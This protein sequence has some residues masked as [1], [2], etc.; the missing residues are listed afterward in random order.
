[1]QNFTSKQQMKA[2]EALAKKK[3]IDKKK[4][5]AM[6][7]RMLALLKIQDTLLPYRILY[8][9]EKA[10]SQKALKN[11]IAPGKYYPLEKLPN[12][13]ECL[14][15]IPACKLDEQA[16]MK[17]RKE[18]QIFEQEEAKY[19]INKDNWQYYFAHFLLPYDIDKFTEFDITGRIEKKVTDQELTKIKQYLS[20][21][22]QD[23][24]EHP[25]KYY[26]GNVTV[27]CN[28]FSEREDN[29]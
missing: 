3:E 1:M 10:E 28:G 29:K 13:V 24:I 8:D 17:L 22:R 12:E 9:L 14:R 7:C 21:V 23:C 4:D 2:M 15:P 20:K 5:I 19:I 27:S 25:E 6:L 26:K 11:D 16:L 18:M